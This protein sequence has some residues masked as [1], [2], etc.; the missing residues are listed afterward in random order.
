MLCRVQNKQYTCL[1]SPINDGGEEEYNKMIGKIIGPK[2][3]LQ[4]ALGQW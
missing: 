2:L 3:M 1:N 4:Y